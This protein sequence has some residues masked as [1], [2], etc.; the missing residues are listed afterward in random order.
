VNKKDAYL[1]DASTGQALFSAI[2]GVKDVT[3]ND[4]NIMSNSIK[5]Q[6]DFEKSVEGTIQTRISAR[7]SRS[8]R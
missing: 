5:Q 1:T 3:I 8:E 4:I 6:A 7:G 2:F